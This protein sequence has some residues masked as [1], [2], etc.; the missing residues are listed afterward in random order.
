MKNTRLSTLGLVLAISL[1]GCAFFGEETSHAYGESDASSAT[2]SSKDA[3]PLEASL[4]FKQQFQQKRTLSDDSMY[5]SGLSSARNKGNNH[6]PNLKLNINHFAS[7]LMQ[8]LVSNFKDVNN[9]T[10]V[11]VTSFVM[12]NSNYNQSTLLGNQL[13]ESLIH[14]LHEHGIPV[15]DYKATGFI[16]ITEQGD[17][18]FS[19]DYEEL[20]KTLNADYILGGTMLKH[21]DGYLINARIVGLENKAVVATAQS[22]IPNN[23][24]KALMTDT[25]DKIVSSNNQSN[26]QTVSLFAN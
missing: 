7:N 12:L 26:R 14:D 16:R 6:P 18:A 9:T 17:F 15:I 3:T 25:Q 4:M 13:A 20:G 8:D 11:A 24:V 23:I 19:K 2:T 22:F 21:K 1:S 5:S 10:S